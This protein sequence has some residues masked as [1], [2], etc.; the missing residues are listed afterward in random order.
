MNEVEDQEH[1]E[2]FSPSTGLDM[3]DDELLNVGDERVST[4]DSNENR[5]DGNNKSFN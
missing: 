5:F 1:E 4:N 2:G 3:Q